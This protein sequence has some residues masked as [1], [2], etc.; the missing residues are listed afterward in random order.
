MLLML[1]LQGVS[2]HFQI[3]LEL[4]LLLKFQSFE[5]FHVLF[6]A[7]VHFG[8]FGVVGEVRLRLIVPRQWLM[9][10][11]KRYHQI[12]YTLDFGC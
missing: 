8:H 10:K 12:L 9:K 6:V 11:S 3:P 4:I 7:L 1:G 2:L 5:L